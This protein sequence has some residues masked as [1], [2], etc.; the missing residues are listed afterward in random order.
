MAFEKT[1]ELYSFCNFGQ[2]NDV[3]VENACAF[4]NEIWTMCGLKKPITS[5]V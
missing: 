5:L 1:E 4:P 3:T 2:L